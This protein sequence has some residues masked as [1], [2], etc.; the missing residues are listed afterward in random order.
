MNFT[1]TQCFENLAEK[2]KMAV[3]INFVKTGEGDNYANKI[4]AK[5][6]PKG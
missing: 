6:C 5:T 4:I 1:L 2:C 3:I